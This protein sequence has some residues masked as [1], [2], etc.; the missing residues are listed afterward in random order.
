MEATRS[1]NQSKK[2]TKAYL[3]IIVAITIGTKVAL[4]SLVLS[5]I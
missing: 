1:Y 5:H 2:V 4:G 3:S